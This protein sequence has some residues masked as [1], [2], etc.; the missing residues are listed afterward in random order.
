M[1]CHYIVSE[2]LF[3][4]VKEYSS[5]DVFNN[6]AIPNGKN[7][8]AVAGATHSVADGL[9]GVLAGG[10]LQSLLSFFSNNNS[11]GGSLNSNPIVGNIINNFKNK[12]TNNYAVSGNQVG[13]I[14]NG[15]ITN[16]LGSL[17]NKTNANSN[18]NFSISSLINTLKGGNQYGNKGSIGNMVSKFTGGCVDVN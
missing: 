8:A 10:A 7:E 11:P 3:N 15:L 14:A 2:N 4:L 18:H 17:I 12:L 6:S 1:L 13:N 9:Q 16:V 5:K